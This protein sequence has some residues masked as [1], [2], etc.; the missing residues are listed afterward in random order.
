M[1][2]LRARVAASPLGPRVQV[3]DFTDDVARFYAAAD[4]LVV[5]SRE[6]EPFGRVATEAMAA[7]LPVIAADHGGLSEIVLHD[8]TGLLV[9]PNDVSGAGRCAVA[10]VGVSAALR[11][12]MGTRGRERQASLFSLQACRQG[13]FKV[14]DEVV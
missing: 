12:Q 2:A 1:E 10:V 4:I 11:R 14:F 6:P 7:A 13:V 8:E 9:P 3:H 5:P